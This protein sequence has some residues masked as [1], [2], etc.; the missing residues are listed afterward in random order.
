[1][2]ICLSD[3]QQS[4]PP[5]QQHPEHLPLQ[6]DVLENEQMDRTLHIPKGNRTYHATIQASV[7]NWGLLGQRGIVYCATPG[8]CESL[9]NGLEQIGM[10][11]S[12]FHGRLPSDEKKAE[13]AQ[14]KERTHDIMVATTAFGLGIDEPDIRFVIHTKL[15]TSMS[16]FLQE[17]GRAGRDGNAAKSM[18]ITSIG[19]QKRSVQHII[20][21]AALTDKQRLLK[22]MEVYVMNTATCRRSFHE[23]SLASIKPLSLPATFCLSQAFQ[24]LY[25]GAT[26]CD[27]CATTESYQIT[28]I[29]IL[30]HVQNLVKLTKELGKMQEIEVTPELLRDIFCRAKVGGKLVLADDMMKHLE[31]IITWEKGKLD[32]ENI[33]EIIARMIWQGVLV[34]T[35]TSTEKR[36][37]S[38]V[39]T[40]D[41]ELQ[42]PGILEYTVKR[43]NKR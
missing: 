29:H 8:E 34:E 20:G 2:N 36:F 12:I 16:T 5:Q 14:W 10:S 40:E 23:R 37:T 35:I 32:K 41:E 26:Y 24:S 6:V 18:V 31:N 17:S 39:S 9:K 25:P 15:P 3:Q 42:I 28:Q 33:D 30:P 13:Y 1:M 43:I 7:T 22:E 11:V 19:L 21:D 38:R 4:D 27:I